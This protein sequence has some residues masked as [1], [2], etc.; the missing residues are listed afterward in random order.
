[1]QSSVKKH[2]LSHSRWSS[3]QHCCTCWRGLAFKRVNPPIICTSCHEELLDCPDCK[4]CKEDCKECQKLERGPS[5]TKLVH[6]PSF[7]WL[8]NHTSNSHLLIW[9]LH[10]IKS[11][12]LKLHAVILLWH[13]EWCSPN[14]DGH[15]DADISLSI[16]TFSNEMTKRSGEI[17]HD[18]PAINDSNK[19]GHV[20][21]K[22][23]VWHWPSDAA[24]QP[25][26]L[27][28]VITPLPGSTSRVTAS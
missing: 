16:L 24:L 22:G 12:Q 5:S 3:N 21:G 19:C 17:R 27:V 1:M 15:A 25:A 2:C 7:F 10:L 9:V 18:G 11:L 14:S 4:V 8:R 20:H 23:H 13:L 28:A 26:E 6:L